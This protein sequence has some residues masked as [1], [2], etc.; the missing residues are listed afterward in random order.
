MKDFLIALKNS[1]HCNSELKLLL[2]KRNDNFWF[3]YP[4][5]FKKDLLFTFD[6]S[7]SFNSEFF[8]IYKS[9]IDHNVFNMPEEVKSFLSKR[10]KAALIVSD[11]EWYFNGRNFYY[12]LHPLKI[13]HKIRQWEK[14]VLQESDIKNY[15]ENIKSSLREKGY[16]NVFISLDGKEF[17]FSNGVLTPFKIFYDYSLKRLSYKGILVVIEGI[18]GSGKSTQA[19]LLRKYFKEKGK[20]VIKFREPS[21]SKWGK[22][23][24]EK[25]KY[26]DGLTSEEQY[27]LF[28]K[29][30]E[31][32]F[33]NNLLP[34]LKKGYI[35]I[36][37]RYY[38]STYAYQGAF[39]LDKRKILRENLRI[40]SPPE[41][42]FILDLPVNEAWKRISD[43]KKDSLF[44]SIE[45]LKEVRENYYDFWGNDVHYISADQPP[46]SILRF[47]SGKVEERLNRKVF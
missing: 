1:S 47:I 34:Y 32:N 6:L 40:C 3:I 28:L 43:R 4:L 41:M 37:D 30:R 25:A 22:R 10:G 13:K 26:S 8:F 17:I 33:K 21:D 7:L 46:D 24:R 38:H 12:E 14:G 16:E 19:E 36:L 15:L 23:I 27:I 29:D 11:E 18:D 2:K 9:Q 35:V 44:E 20:K 31:H 42:L 5:K 39:G 45:F